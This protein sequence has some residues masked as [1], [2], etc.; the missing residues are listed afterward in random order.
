[1]ADKDMV[2]KKERMIQYTVDGE[3]VTRL[4][5]EQ[6]YQ[7]GRFGWAMKLLA[8]CLNTNQLTE[9]EIRHMAFDI[10]NGEAEICGVYPGDDYGI[11]YDK[12]NPTWDIATLIEGLHQRCKNLEER[13]E[14]LDTKI[15][16]LLEQIPDEEKEEINN[17]YYEIY[18]HY[19][20]RPGD[21]LVNSF[22][23]RMRNEDKVGSEYGWLEPSGTFHEVDFMEHEDFAQSWVHEHFPEKERNTSGSLSTYDDVPSTS[24]PYGDY[25][26]GHGWILLHNPYRGLAFL[27]RDETRRMTQAQKDFLYDYYMAR[28]R[29]DKAYELFQED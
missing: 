1:M 24:H 23:Q 25:L 4:A 16:F 5:R 20:F 17:T 9:L 2:K 10:L 7:E 13:C 14:K 22:L 21:N 8:G 26:V 27:T 18:N 15:S 12:K 6:C 11:D 19:L 28:N 29:K 3:G